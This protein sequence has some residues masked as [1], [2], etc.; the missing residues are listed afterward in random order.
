VL[1]IKKAVK[2]LG[3]QGKNVQIRAYALVEKCFKVVL[4]MAASG[5]NTARVTAAIANMG[6]Q[7]MTG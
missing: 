5:D 7:K 4:E 1:A 3:E 2:G 6:C